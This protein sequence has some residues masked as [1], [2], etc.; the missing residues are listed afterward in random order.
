[1]NMSMIMFDDVNYYELRVFL[2][3]TLHFSANKLCFEEGMMEKVQETM[4][5]RHFEDASCL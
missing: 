5:F 4:V 1:M 2:R 3:E